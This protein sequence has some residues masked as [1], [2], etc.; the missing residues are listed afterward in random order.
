MFFVVVFLGFVLFDFDTIRGFLG[1]WIGP[2]LLLLIRLFSFDIL[3]QLLLEWKLERELEME[4]EREK[5]EEVVRTEK[6]EATWDW[7]QSLI[8]WYLDV[9]HPLAV[10]SLS[11][12]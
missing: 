7:Y 11:F 8:S 1:I 5:P 4:K 10:R 6:R 9:S 2:S 3:L 12:F